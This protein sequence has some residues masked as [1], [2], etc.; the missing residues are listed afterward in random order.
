MRIPTRNRDILDRSM[1]K[2]K[3]KSLTYPKIS[4]L[5]HRDW[6]ITG[7]KAIITAN[8]GSEVRAGEGSRSLKLFLS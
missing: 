7:A 8:P 1:R 6:F 4:F 3:L 2:V 5:D